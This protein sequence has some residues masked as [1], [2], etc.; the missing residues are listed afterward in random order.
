[1]A[2]RTDKFSRYARHAM[3]QP[4]VWLAIMDLAV[5]HFPANLRQYACDRIMLR[6]VEMEYAL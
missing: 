5:R 4:F 3:K 1:M 2:P 6:V